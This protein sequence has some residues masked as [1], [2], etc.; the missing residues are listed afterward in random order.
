MV[1][2]QRA[3]MASGLRLPIISAPEEVRIKRLFV[4][5]LLSL[6]LVVGGSGADANAS[7]GSL[8]LSPPIGPPTTTVAAKATG[9]ASREQVRIA[10]DGS[11]LTTKTSSSTGSVSTSFAVPS[12]ASPGRHIVTATGAKSGVSRAATFTVR[13]AYPFVGFDAAHTGFNPYENTINRANV[14]RLSLAW[15]RPLS[16]APLGGS[17]VLTQDGTVVV[18]GGDSQLHAFNASSGAPLWTASSGSTLS[19]AI[20]N[21]LAYVGDVTALKTTSGAIGWQTDVGQEVEAA[22]VVGDGLVFASLN[23][24]ELVAL[25]AATGKFVWGS[26]AAMSYVRESSPAFLNHV[27]YAGDDAGKLWAVKAATGAVLWHV[28]ASSGSD[29]STPVASGT[30]VY[31]S[32]GRKISAYKTSSGARAW[33][34]D[35]GSDYN[36]GEPAI[37]RGVVYIGS[38][39]GTVFALDAASGNQLWA[40]SI[41]TQNTMVSVANGVVFAAADQLVALDAA[42]GEVLWS[43]E[44]GGATTLGSSPAVANGY[45][46]VAGN[47]GVLYAYRLV[48]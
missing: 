19:A 4:P 23:D 12:S 26:P 38:S 13:T 9:F 25:N 15:S 20:S 43:G 36:T 14:D 8:S 47:D 2:F 29:V 11:T 44:D 35:L 45:V 10:F 39:D 18:P 3:R 6:A 48:P 21:H 16:G 33:A 1:I 27:V 24:P 34:S 41:G 30:R 5:A 46:Y 7:G 28:T 17:P 22:P 40:K 42:T 31:V 32:S 37:A